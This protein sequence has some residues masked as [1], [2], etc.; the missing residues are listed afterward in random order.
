MKKWVP[1]IIVLFLLGW[2]VYDFIDTKSNRLNIATNEDGD[3]LVGL[4][5]GYQAPD[6]ELE[7][8]SGEVIRLSDFKGEKVMIN[9]WASWCGPCRSEM[10]DME[11]FY[12]DKDVKILAVNVT[13]TERSLSH[14][15]DF[16]DEIS[17][18]FPVLLDENR[19]VSNLYKIQP[20]P[21]TFMVDSSGIINFKT[22]G[23]M[24]YDSM[25]R[26]FEKMK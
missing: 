15:T 6:F 16:I 24:N 21:T 13:D 23:A 9:F 5:V 12:H 11:K 1:M 20:L 19:D 7:T 25:V 3:V 4:D 22:Y 26:E 18:T 14:V 17:A 10:P 8:L 2:A